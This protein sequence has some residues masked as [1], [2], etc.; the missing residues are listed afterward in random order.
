VEEHVTAALQEAIERL[1]RMREDE[2]GGAATELKERMHHLA[3][4]TQEVDQLRG[5]DGCED[6]AATVR[7]AHDRGETLFVAF[8]CCGGVRGK[9]VA[10]ALRVVGIDQLEDRGHVAD[11]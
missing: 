8:G 10:D 4:A 1:N 11:Y 2:G 9:Q 3:N 6:V 5:K 7:R